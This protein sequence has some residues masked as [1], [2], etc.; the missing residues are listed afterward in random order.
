MAVAIA[1][2]P[3][4]QLAGAIEVA[5]KAH[6]SDKTNWRNMLTNRLDTGIDLVREKEKAAGFLEDEL[7]AAP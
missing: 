6:M 5:L 1:H 7:G 3:Y 2:T 4:R